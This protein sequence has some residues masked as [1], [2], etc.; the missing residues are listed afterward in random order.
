MLIALLA[1]TLASAQLNTQPIDG[2]AGPSINQQFF[3]EVT[4]LQQE[5]DRALK[6]ERQQA[7]KDQSECIPQKPGAGLATS[8]ANVISRGIQQTLSQTV[9]RVIAQNMRNI[10]QRQVGQVLPQ[11]IQQG[12][13][14]QLPNALRQRFRGMSDSE[15]NQ[16]GPAIMQ[17]EV[18]RLLPG[19]IR[20]D[21][22]GA[23]QTGVAGSLTQHLTT[24]YQNQITSGTSTSPTFLNAP[25]FQSLLQ[26]IFGSLGI[27]GQVLGPERIT[28]LVQQMVD[29]QVGELGDAVINGDFESAQAEIKQLQKLP[30]TVVTTILKQ[31]K[32]AMDTMLANLANDIQRGMANDASN[33]IAKGDGMALLV[34]KM[35]PVIMQVLL[36]GNP[37]VSGSNGLSSQ[38]NDARFESAVSGASDSYNNFNFNDFAGNNITAAI[39]FDLRPVSEAIAQP[40]SIAVVSGLGVSGYDRA[41]SNLA[42]A[43]FQ[44]TPTIADLQFAGQLNDTGANYLGAIGN[45]YHGPFDSATA[46]AL[47][48]GDINSVL[49]SPVLPLPTANEL[50]NPDAIATFEANNP[51]LIGP[52][53]P[54]QIIGADAAANVDGGN[55]ANGVGND[56]SNSLSGLGTQIGG[57]LQAGLVNGISS[58]VGGLVDG[59]PYVG[60][61]LAP[62][63][64]QVVQT[65]LNAAIGPITLDGKLAVS[66]SGL[67]R[68]VSK[69]SQAEIKAITKPLLKIEGFEKY[70]IEQNKT[71]IKQL[72]EERK[73][74]ELQCA[75]NK[76]G[77]DAMENLD[78]LA[79]VKNPA[80][81]YGSLAIYGALSSDWQKIKDAATDSVL[82]GPEAEKEAL[83]I[84]ASKVLA[85]AAEEGRRQSL[86]ESALGGSENTK[87]AAKL[88]D[89]TSRTTGWGA[90]TL[91]QAE[92]QRLGTTATA[93]EKVDSL[94]QVYS[95]QND[96]RA[97]Y[98]TEMDKTSTAIARKMTEA[99][100]Q[101]VAAKGYQDSRECAEYV[102]SPPLQPWCKTWK[103]KTPG[104]VNAE[105]D[106]KLATFVLDKLVQANSFKEAELGPSVSYMM[107]L[108]GNYG[109]QPEELSKTL[110]SPC[111]GI[112]PCDPKTGYDSGAYARASSISYNSAND[113]DYLK[114]SENFAQGLDIAVENGLNGAFFTADTQLSNFTYN[115]TNGINSAQFSRNDT[116]QQS[117]TMTNVITHALDQTGGIAQADYPAIIAKLLQLLLQRILNL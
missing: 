59:I 77:K 1:P 10:I 52:P 50:V 45:V 55:I 20:N 87:A 69:T 21:F 103:V 14:Q 4:Q 110:V 116:F 29:E 51:D 37:N 48:N 109:L 7:A 11:V 108:L 67:T 35:M 2:V 65:A 68:T 88:I 54:E 16:R 15:R 85:T 18:R 62:I 73:R 100:T 33:G 80:A 24:D 86:G 47:N 34:D 107:Q 17:E 28:A 44:G 94:P 25:E 89:R 72:E 57:Q 75:V 97:A 9:N 79:R 42:V 83:F 70:Q 12:L 56:F 19:I 78:E 114:I 104:A 26:A 95:P 102:V 112:E 64:E 23:L 76:K 6:E 71:Q 82:G 40:L 98:L 13:S 49:P 66:D 27:I 93:R 106:A 31:V 84:P 105:L 32:G 58:G 101:I 3:N 30:T 91:T 41:V 36:N 111:P 5:A 60:G 63:A 61:L 43:G 90:Q 92:Q 96:S 38:F 39:G 117:Q 53:T 46:T 81:F 74:I 113:L 99:V 8:F 22:P 115:L